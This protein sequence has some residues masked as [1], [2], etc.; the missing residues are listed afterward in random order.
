MTRAQSKAYEYSNVNVYATK[1]LPRFVHHPILQLLFLAWLLNNTAN[2]QWNA[3]NPV[4]SVQQQ[5]EAAQIALKSGILKLQV[6]GDSIVHVTYS[7]TS[8]IPEQKNFVVV[9]NSWPATRWT[10]NSGQDAITIT[11]SQLKITVLRKDASVTFSDSAG[12]QLFQQ[13]EMNL[14]PVVV[15][16]Q[17]TYHAELYSKLWAPTSRSTDW[18][19]IRQECGT[20]AEKR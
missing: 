5:A 6:C 19:S 17:K 13:T 20:I 14:Q 7:P 16:G 18:A 2:A 15:N 4:V 3:L 12:R 10:M 11:T 8:Q 9:K 1:R